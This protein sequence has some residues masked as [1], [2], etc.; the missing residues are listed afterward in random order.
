MLDRT[1]KFRYNRACHLVL[2]IPV[3]NT[4]ENLGQEI[5]IL[6]LQ[7]KAEKE[8]MTEN[9]TE[10]MPASNTAKPHITYR[11]LFWLFIAGSLAGVILEGL[12]C[13]YK[14][15]HWETHVV[16]LGVPLC[17]IY[18]FGAAGCYAGHVLLFGKSKWVQFLIYSLVGFSI[19]LLSGCLLEFGLSMRAWSYCHQ[20]LNIRG[21]VSLQMTLAWGVIGIAFSSVVPYLENHL[22][23]METKPWKIICYILTVAVAADLLLTSVAI[24]RWSNRHFQIPPS[25]K[26][27]QLIDEKF[28]DEFMEKRF[29][30]W[31]FLDE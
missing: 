18:G 27:E 1:V 20:F 3:V 26:L 19:E 28:N 21:H 24:L 7:C 30:E 31:R 5:Y 13:I 23:K 14:Y 9:H 11:K 15:G 2:A 29:C 16:S 17:I 6:I 25:N 8:N 22:S 4:A 10:Q 12:F